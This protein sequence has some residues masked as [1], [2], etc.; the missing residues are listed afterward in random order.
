MSLLR[1]TALHRTYRGSSRGLLRPARHI[2]AVN[3]VDLEL[4][5]G[6]RVGIVGESGCGKSTLLRLLLALEAPDAGKVHYQ[7]R[8]VLPDRAGRLRWFRSEVQMIPQDPWSSLNPRM[9]VGDVVAEPLRC[10]RIP[11]EHDER[12]AEV[13]RA[14]GLEPET[15]GHRPG[16][17]SGGQ[18]Q[19]IAIARALAP[20]PRFLLADEPVTALDASVR[21]RVLHFLRELVE[22]EG[23]GLLL[24]THDLAVVR[25]VCDRVLVMR[26]G[27]IVERGSVGEIF[28]APRHDYTRALLSSVPSLADV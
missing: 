9:R 17:F 25:R 24:V 28:D 22:R 3:G 7:D 15:A 18:R 4:A 16:E 8:R 5:A 11:G 1:A 10:L 12:V 27:E 6:E 26:A 19:R 14:V 13:L 23:L 2:P 21:S 20:S